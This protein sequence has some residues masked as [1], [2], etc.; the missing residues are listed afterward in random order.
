MLCAAVYAGGVRRAVTGRVGG[1]RCVLGVG[2]VW[3]VLN[4]RCG[5]LQ[6]RLGASNGCVPSSVAM[7]SV[8]FSRKIVADFKVSARPT[9]TEMKSSPSDI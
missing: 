7:P 4:F 1:M 9:S 8:A 5:S 3:G 6:V 2:S